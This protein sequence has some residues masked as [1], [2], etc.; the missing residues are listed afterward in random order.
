MFSSIA[1][2]LNTM[3][4]CPLNQF[5]LQ[6]L[7]NHVVMY[8][9]LPLCF[10]TQNPRMVIFLYYFSSLFYQTHV[11]MYQLSETPAICVLCS[12]CIHTCSFQS[13][14]SQK[15]CL[16][17]FSS[18]SLFKSQSWSTR[19]YKSHLKFKGQLLK[20]KVHCTSQLS[21]TNIRSNPNH[22]RYRPS[23]K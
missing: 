22:R 7:A 2:C 23:T 8:H 6:N 13:D 9:V 21:Q 4:S 12:F 16:L 19:V 3:W 5:V 11:I 17:C 18:D 20:S 10:A 1:L 15:Y 14:R